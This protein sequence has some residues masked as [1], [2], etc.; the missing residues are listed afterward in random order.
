LS[1][2]NPEEITMMQMEL[3]INREGEKFRVVAQL[4]SN[5]VVFF[6]FKG[7]FVQL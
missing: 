3:K 6:K 2:V 7:V 4:L 1:V 5:A